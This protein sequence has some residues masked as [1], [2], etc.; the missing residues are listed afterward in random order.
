MREKTYE[1]CI[2]IKNCMHLYRKL[3]PPKVKPNHIFVFYN[4]KIPENLI[5]DN[6]DIFLQ[7]LHLM[8]DQMIFFMSFVNK[9]FTVVCIF[10]LKILRCFA[11]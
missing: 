8:S 3:L 2:E 10:L 4:R 6:P 7:F 1:N 5:I 11:S 9:Y